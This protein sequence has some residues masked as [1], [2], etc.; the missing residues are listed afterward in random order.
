MDHISTGPLLKRF[1]GYTVLGDETW[2]NTSTKVNVQGNTMFTLNG[3]TG[4]FA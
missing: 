3:T 4:Y 2:L 1:A